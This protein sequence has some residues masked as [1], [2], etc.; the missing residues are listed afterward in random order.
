M[1]QLLQNSGGGASIPYV[2][3]PGNHEVS[4]LGLRP[5]T[6]GPNLT[7]FDMY[8]SIRLLS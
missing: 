3:L 6:L 8:L 4:G 7:R 1:A 5:W 2:F